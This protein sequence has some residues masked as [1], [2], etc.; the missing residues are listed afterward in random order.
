MKFLSFSLLLILSA[1]ASDYR[2]MSQITAAREC[3]NLKPLAPDNALFNAKIDVLG[4]HLSGL[5]LVKQ[6]DKAHRVVFTNEAGV[7][8]FDFSFGK[9]GSFQVI[10]VIDQLNKKAVINLLR[11]DFSLMLGLPFRNNEAQSFSLGNEI[12]FGVSQ[13]KETAYFITD[14]DCASLQRLE[15]GSSRKRK[16]T[17]TFTGVPEKPYTVQIRHHTFDMVVN[18]HL[19]ERNATE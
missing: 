15:L 16:V 5:L 2:G 3:L 7:T 1:C 14:K 6:V 4:K 11:E 13:K 9:D 18:L 10:K 12:F 17:V 19:I 8:F